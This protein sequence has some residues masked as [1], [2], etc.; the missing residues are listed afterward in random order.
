VGGVT[1]YYLMDD[2]NPSG[3]A[4][5]VEEITASAG[6]TNLTKV[7]AYGLDLISRQ[8]PGVA[9][10]YY[11]HDGHGS[12]RYLTGTSGDI[13][14][15][16]TYDAFGNLIASSGST[17]NNYLYCGEQYDPQLKFYYNR[18][19]Y[20]NPDT[21]RFWTMDTFAGNNE[22]PLS[23][24]KY[25]YCQD[26]PVDGTDPSGRSVYVCT[27]PLD[28]KGHENDGNNACHVFLA[29]DTDGMNNIA[30]WEDTV[31][32]SWDAAKHP[33]TYGIQYYG[34][35]DNPTF[36]FHPK[37]VLNGDESGEYGGPLLTP[38]S[39]VADQ[40]GIDQRAVNKT[41]IGYNKW[42][43]AKGNDIQMLIFEQAVRSRD[44]NNSGTPDP[45]PYEFSVFNCGSWVQFILGNNHIAFPDKTIN[46]GVGLLTTG[47]NGYTA[48]GYVA[49]AAAKTWRGCGLPQFQIPNLSGFFDGL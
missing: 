29:F 42:M 35:P 26:E 28:I 7:Y 17:E 8:Q 22:D 31:R 27:R 6:A 11:G 2:R 19:R 4:Q 13:T 16:Y 14:D 34:D 15:T 38:G 36:S 5:V 49:N 48:A 47:S 45:M 12:V 23:L 44:K 33:N 46:H 30:A 32:E 3:Y 24:H 10:N 1:T 9:T 40:A 41:G 37:S 18:A 39:Y 21:G 43:V 20:L 25:L